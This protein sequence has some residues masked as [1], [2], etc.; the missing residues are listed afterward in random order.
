ML[1]TLIIGG[2]PAGLATAVALAMRGRHPVVLEQ[3]TGTLDKACGEGLMPATWRDLH[4][5]GVQPTRVHPFVGIRYQTGTS[6]ADGFFP[7]GPGHGVRRLHLHEALSR[8][9]DQLGIERRVH[10]AT[11]IRQDSEGVT[12]DGFRARYLVAADG[13]RSPTRHALGLN[14]PSRRSPRLGQRQHFTCAPWSPFVEVHWAEDIEA[15]VTP[16]DAQTVGV[17]FLFSPGAQTRGSG[18]P[19]EN[20]MAHL[21]V[22]RERLADAPPASH[23]R[24][25]GPFAQIS[26]SPVAG[27]T[28]LVGD[29]AGYLDPLTGEGLKLAIS[30]ALAA[31]D[32]IAEENVSA[33]APRWR[34]AYRRYWWPTAG[35]LAMTRSRLVRRWMVPVL[36]RTPALFDRILGVVGG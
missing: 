20:L 13:L 35:L 6:W 2:G 30:G 9:V 16:V 24:G 22:L 28:L 17:A 26:R 23:V 19:F 27:R 25:A 4:T 12:V 34:A 36:R 29:A 11:D 8:R 15:Y 32:A 33:Y 21:P 14:V 18:T 5:L 3:H 7:Q 31:A 1:D 10:R